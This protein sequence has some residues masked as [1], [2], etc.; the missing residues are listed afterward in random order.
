MWLEILKMTG[1]LATAFLAGWLALDKIT[2]ESRMAADREARVELM[3]RFVSDP[4]DLND[5]FRSIALLV[6][7]G[8]LADVDGKLTMEVERF[9]AQK[10]GE[11][12]LG[13]IAVAPAPARRAETLQQLTTTGPAIAPPSP[14]AP[15]PVVVRSPGDV[16]AQRVDSLN[17]STPSTRTATAQQI[18][19]AIR[20]NGLPP[21]EQL[22]VATAL[23]DLADNDR[24]RGLSQTGRY[25]LIYVLSEVP[26]ANWS[27]PD[28]A[29]LSNDLRGALTTLEK[30]A[31][32]GVTVI[33]ADTRR[34]L[35]VLKGR[36][37]QV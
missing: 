14:L 19:S 34:Y 7:T 28:W 21:P 33:G 10:I 29:T 26:A 3:K 24:M 8:M 1:G 35:D 23:V 32:D 12:P 31:A 5:V 13:S 22:K 20:D 18:I 9:F 16:L 6:R 27:N 17:A 30:R 36:L 2:Y 15:V 37:G 4:D 11:I 25:N